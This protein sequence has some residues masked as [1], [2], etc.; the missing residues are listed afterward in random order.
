MDDLEAI[1]AFKDSFS[2]LDAWRK[3][4]QSAPEEPDGHSVLA[5]DDEAWSWMPLSSVAWGKLVGA[6]D[7]L[8]AARVLVE[9]ESF[10]PLATYTLT[11][12]ALIASSEALWLLGPDDADLRR[13]RGLWLAKETHMEHVKFLREV[14]RQPGALR[15]I[16]FVRAVQE[17]H[18][19]GIRY[20]S[21]GLP[22]PGPTDA[23]GIVDWTARHMQPGRE[24]WRYQARAQLRQG[25]GDA[26]SVMW[27]AMSRSPR[28]AGA[29]SDGRL[30]VFGAGGSPVHAWRAYYV[31]FEVM[32]RAWAR[33][34]VLRC[35]Q[36]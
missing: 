17:A 4:A 8:Q 28:D 25:G 12:S 1:S 15:A 21:A 29:A 36:L 19:V 13:A 14:R 31:P 35:A 5:V 30:H 16:S 2:T 3:R 22:G 24:H 7:H 27:S 26:H 9:A 18:I 6:V 34:D 33:W 11:R 32:R 20:A 10:H 23:L